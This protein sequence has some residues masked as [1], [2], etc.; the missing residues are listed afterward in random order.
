MTKNKRDINQEL[1][2]SIEHVKAYKRGEMQFRTTIVDG[3]ARQRRKLSPPD[4]VTRKEMTS[5][6]VIRARL[7]LTQEQ[8]AARLR[9]S[10]RTLQDWEQG[11][12]Q[13][14][15]PALSLL[16]IAEQEPEVF[17]RVR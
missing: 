6:K 5:P 16:R 8:F 9:V 12:R 1:L 3:D 15:G 10:V 7:N 11:R 2:E 17:L 13:P 4:N 14:S